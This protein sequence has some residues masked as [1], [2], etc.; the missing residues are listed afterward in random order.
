V[1]SNAPA[2]RFAF[3]S[4]QDAIGCLPRQAPFARSP[5]SALLR[6]SHRHQARRAE[7]DTDAGATGTM[8]KNWHP[9]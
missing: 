2:R 7:R 5:N 1:E 6:H 3:R 9:W 4:R 8:A